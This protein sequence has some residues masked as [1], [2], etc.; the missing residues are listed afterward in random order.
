MA[1]KTKSTPKTQNVEN[2]DRRDFLNTVTN[3]FGAVGAACVA[4]PFIKSMSPSAD[5]KAQA[6]TDVDLSVLAEGEGKVVMW[7][8][9]PVFVKHRTP[10]EIKEARSVDVS[11]LIDPQ[12][13]AE[14]VKN[15]KYLVVVGV[16]THLGCVPMSGGK[17]DGWLCPCH[18][19]QFDGSGR[20]RRGPAPTNLE[21]PPYTFLDE[22]TI[23]IG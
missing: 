16:C 1:D 15:E 7:R 20:V 12:T 11:E 14:R 10:Q 17:H 6:T 18:G 21:V 9:K 5:V 23:R 22:T 8:G 2:A 4:Y 3:T 19:S 13:D